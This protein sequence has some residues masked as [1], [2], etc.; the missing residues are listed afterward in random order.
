M[1]SDCRAVLAWLSIIAHRNK[2]KKP[3]EKLI[4][5]SDVMMEYWATYG[6]NF[7]SRYD[8][9]VGTCATIEVLFVKYSWHL[10]R[11]PLVWNFLIP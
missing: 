9:E 7:F 3:E 8:Y 6:R 4:S 5:V 10:T 2:D 1:I 11:S